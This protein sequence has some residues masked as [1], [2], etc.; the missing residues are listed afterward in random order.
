MLA[1]AG[2]GGALYF[3]KAKQAAELAYED[4]D[5]QEPRAKAN[6]NRRDLS[7]APVFVALDLFTVNLPDREADR[8][9]QAT[10]SLEVDDEKAAEMLK[11]FMPPIRNSILMTL[12]YK[13]SADLLER[14]G[15]AT[16]ADAVG[17]G[18]DEY[19]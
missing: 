17:T 15:H 10:I 9:V 7:I 14:D 4:E 2:G 13:T 5:D 11:N 18:I 12:S 3:I 19:A 8:Y 16:V 1:L 6:A